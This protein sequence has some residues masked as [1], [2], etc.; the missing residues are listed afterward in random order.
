MVP[1]QV[2]TIAQMPRT[3]SG[4]VDRKVLERQAL[5]T[6][7]PPVTGKEEQERPSRQEPSGADLTPKDI[8]R[9]VLGK[10]PDMEKSFLCRAEPH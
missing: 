3:S 9:E 7:V 4:K 10:E 1:A 8:W 6:A 5:Q 2:K